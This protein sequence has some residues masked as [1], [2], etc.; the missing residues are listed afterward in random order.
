MVMNRLETGRLV[1]R[2]FRAADGDAYAGLWADGDTVRHLP[3]GTTLA[4]RPEEVAKW[5]IRAFQDHWAERG[6]GPFAVTERDSG[7]LLGHCG[8]RFLNQRRETEIIFMIDR[9][10]RGRGLATEAAQACLGDGFTRL[11]LD[12][13]I[14]MI[15]P[16][17]TAAAAVLRRCGMEAAGG[18]LF[19]GHKVHLF[20]RWR[21]G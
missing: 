6:Y 14:G 17:N 5:A 11:R 13:I 20:E 2:T 18:T 12:R 16:G 19:N 7:I 21:A 4:T 3:G 8:L 9:R 10:W 15:D 1:L